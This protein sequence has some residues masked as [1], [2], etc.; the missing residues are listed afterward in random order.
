V[1]DPKPEAGYYYRSDHISLGKL[2]VP[3]L[4]SDSGIDHVQHGKEYG[5][6]FSQDYTDN[7]YHK[8][9]DEYDD[10]WDL[11]G[12]E[13]TSEILFELGYDLANSRDWPNWYE[14]TEFRSLRD[15]MMAE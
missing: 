2:G 10:S 15:K 5:E 14:G 6:K 11:S 1:P 12:L 8:P 7:R 9:S 3:M 13:L 4:Y